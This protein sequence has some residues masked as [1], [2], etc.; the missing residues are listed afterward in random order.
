VHEV[1]T[2]RVGEA[3]A[4]PGWRLAVDSDGRPRGWVDPTEPAG[5][6]RPGG[7]LH[8][9][10]GPMR[11]ALDASLSSPSGLGVVIDGDGSA[12]GGVRAEDV[13]AAWRR[14]RGADAR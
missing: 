11:T 13:L 12:V 2:V 9:R 5:A 10:G 3:S 6:L 14:R 4:G 7:S 8:R 1:P